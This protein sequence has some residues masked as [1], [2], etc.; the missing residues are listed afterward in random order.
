MPK[1]LDPNQEIHGLM[2]DIAVGG[3][4][5]DM[6]EN[7]HERDLRGL[8][9]DTQSSAKYIIEPRVGLASLVTRL[10]EKGG[11]LLDYDGP[12]L[13][14]MIIRHEGNPDHTLKVGSMMDILGLSKRNPAFDPDSLYTTTPVTV[15]R[16]LESGS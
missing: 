1:A 4:N 2:N 7:W 6:L 15:I 10:S 16:Y 14:V 9:V 3:V 5:V 12:R 13:R 8:W 11:P